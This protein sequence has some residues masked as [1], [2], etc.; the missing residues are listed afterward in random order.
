MEAKSPTGSNASPSIAQMQCLL[1]SPQSFPNPPPLIQAP[2]SLYLFARQTLAHALQSRIRGA[3]DSQESW[4]HSKSKYSR[5]RRIYGPGAVCGR[6]GFGGGWG[7]DLGAPLSRPLVQENEEGGR[8]TAR[9]W[10][11]AFARSGGTE[12][13]PS[14]STWAR[15]EQQRWMRVI[16]SGR[17][18]PSC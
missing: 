1:P 10:M 15:K 2:P 5:R 4:S 17:V 14:T 9:W 16:I 6:G 11:V 12:L 3:E 18:L 13:V 8:E 7:S